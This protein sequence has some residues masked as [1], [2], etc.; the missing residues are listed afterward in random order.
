MYLYYIFLLENN[1]IFLKKC[2]FRRILQLHTNPKFYFTFD[3][4]LQI[5]I[6]TFDVEELE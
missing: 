1:L 5:V 6:L 4:Y 3:Q 2:I